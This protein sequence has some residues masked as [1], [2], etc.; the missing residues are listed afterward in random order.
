QPLRRGGLSATDPAPLGEGLSKRSRPADG[1]NG[2]SPR[3]RYQ[4]PRTMIR[5]N[6]GMER[7][8]FRALRET[9]AMTVVALAALFGLRA[10][11]ILAPVPIGVLV[12]VTVFALT[13]TTTVTYVKWARRLPLGLRVGLQ[14]VGTTSVID[15]TGWGPV[16]SVGFV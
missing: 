6:K 10:I 13:L 8:P 4:F 16:L 9:L 1:Q 12:G 15:A 5:Q 14:V 7:S 2:L 3:G 11:R